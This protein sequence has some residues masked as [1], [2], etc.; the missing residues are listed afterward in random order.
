MGLDDRRVR[1]RGVWLVPN[2]LRG[3]LRRTEVPD[4]TLQDPQGLGALTVRGMP[5]TRRPPHALA[6]KRTAQRHDRKGLL[7]DA[8]ITTLL[9]LRTAAY[10]RDD[11]LTVIAIDRLLDERRPL[12]E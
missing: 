5:E 7:G 6:R 9:R 8:E 2:V 10:G 3:A 1:E 4:V 12:Q 11:R